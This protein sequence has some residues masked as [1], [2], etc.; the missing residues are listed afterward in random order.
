MVRYADNDYYLSI[1]GTVVD[2]WGVEVTLEYVNTSVETTSGAGVDHVMRSPGLYD[3][4]ISLSIAY[5]ATDL[6]TYIQKLQ[7]GVV[8]SIEY[9]PEGSTSGKPRHVQN[10]NITSSPFTVNINKEMP[11]FEV[12]AEGT[13]AAS[14]NMYA[15]GVYS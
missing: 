8:V 3:T 1:G 5:D 6:A 7:P 9:G 10:F 13:E 11:V 14:V 4:T 2:T 15:G 12:E